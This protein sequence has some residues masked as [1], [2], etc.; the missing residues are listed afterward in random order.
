VG[1]RPIS[2]RICL[3]VL[4]GLASVHLGCTSWEHLLARTDQSALRRSFLEVIRSNG[5]EEAFRAAL[6]ELQVGKQDWKVETV[7]SVPGS[8]GLVYVEVRPDPEYPPDYDAEMQRM[9]GPDQFWFFFDASGHLLAWSDS[10]GTWLLADVT[11]DG[12]KDLLVST[13]SPDALGKPQQ[14]GMPAHYTLF[15]TSS[16]KP[17]RIPFGV[18]PN[19]GTIYGF[20]LLRLPESSVPLV[21]TWEGNVPSEDDEKPGLDFPRTVIRSFKA[22]RP[23]VVLMVGDWA[24]LVT[25]PGMAPILEPE[26]GDRKY[27]VRYNYM[28]RS[29][30]L[31]WLD[32]GEKD[33]LLLFRSSIVPR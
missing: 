24:K 11:G 30:D 12:A 32:E 18:G 15:V 5:I 27:R 6:L 1:R 17:Q 10:A 26:G 9:F 29:F 3:V 28:T 20:A 25:D 13:D 8:N 2:A 22:G 16:E 7:R 14:P 4:F 19:A 31:Q 21:M 33:P 23:R